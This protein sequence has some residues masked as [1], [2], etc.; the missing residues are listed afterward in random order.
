MSKTIGLIERAGIYNDEIT[1]S[2]VKEVPI[3]YKNSETVCVVDYYGSPNYLAGIL[4]ALPDNNII[5]TE[6]EQ[7]YNNYAS[8]ILN[9]LD[10]NALKR[11]KFKKKEYNQIM[12]NKDMMELIGS[13]AIAISNKP[14]N[15]KDKEKTQYGSSY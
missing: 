1:A 14:Y 8:E 15:E 10:N 12:G 7:V 6:S 13:D 5:A 11:L 9:V 2:Q 3:D 4:G